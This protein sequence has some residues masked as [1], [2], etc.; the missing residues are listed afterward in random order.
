MS[1]NIR[2]LENKLTMTS[3]V[4]KVSIH[5]QLSRSY[6][7][8]DV[9]KMYHHVSEALSL[10][11]KYELLDEKA[12][13]YY[14]LGCYYYLSNNYKLSIDYFKQALLLCPSQYIDL[15]ASIYNRVGI[16]YALIH[17]FDKASKYV[18]KAIELVSASSHYKILC[19]AYISM[20]R[21]HRYLEEYDIADYYYRESARIAESNNLTHMV[22][23]T[24]LVITH[25]KLHTFEL[26]IEKNLLQIENYM[27]EHD[28]LWYLGPTKVMWAVYY[29]LSDAKDV[30][31][32][33]YE[34][35]LDILEEEKQFSTLIATYT[36]LTFALEYKNYCD[37]ALE[38]L[39]RAEAFFQKNDYSFG[40]P[41][42]YLALSKFYSRQG[43]VKLYQSYLRKYVASKERLDGYMNQY[44]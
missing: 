24:L 3:D 29:I 16:Y 12:T 28:D 32:I 26:N 23:D 6:M 30:A 17:N 27:E 34:M 19:S 8:R 11:E 2:L 25:N 35:A 31:T 9:N 10:S 33:N 15:K 40:L 14:Y 5:N 42:L 18:E 37:E 20:G 36:I 43:K 1:E 7:Y 4:E 39:L 21:I 41:K 22:P 44:F 13:A 38:L